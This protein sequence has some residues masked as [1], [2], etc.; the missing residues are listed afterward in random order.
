M[1]RV[2]SYL[3]LVFMFMLPV[4]VKAATVSV[5]LK[6]PSSA[7]AGTT[8]DCS[9]NVSTNTPI[10]GIVG[11][12]TLVGASYVSFTPQSGFSANYVSKDGFN[13]GNNAGRI[14][15]YSAGTLKVKVT[16]AASITIR[17][18]DISDTA[19]Q[20]YTAAN[21]TATIK[22]K[23]SNNKLSGLSLSEGRLSPAFSAS[24]LSY[25]ATV[26]SSSVTINASKGESSQTVTGTGKK[27]LNYGKNTFKVVVKSEAGTTGTYV[28]VITRPDNRSS[29][30]NLKSLSVDVGSINFKAST[31][32]Y[33][34]NVG[35]DVSSMKISADI[36]DS[37]A[38]FVKNYGARTV[39]LSYG[40]SSHQVKVKAENGSVK[41]YTIKVNREDG[42]SSNT[43]LKSLNLSSGSISFSKDVESY[44]TSVPYDVTSIVVTAEAE[45]S[46]S[47]VDVVSPSLVV[48]ENTIK[49]TVISESGA[50]R[51]YTINVTRLEEAEV[52]SNNNNVSSID[53]L[54]HGINFDPETEI[55]EINIGDE[56]ALVIEVLLED[57][58]AK[59]VIEGNENLKDGSV[60]KITSTSENGESKEYK[61]LVNKNVSAK[62]G[63]SSNSLLVGLIGFV[64]G[65]VTMFA[66]MTIIGKMKSNKEDVKVVSKPVVGSAEVKAAPVLAKPEVKVVSQPTQ[67][68]QSKVE[69]VSQQVSQPKV[70]KPVQAPVQESS[71]PVQQGQAAPATKPVSQASVQKVAQNTPVQAA[72]VQQ[73]PVML[74]ADV[75]QPV[76]QDK[77]QIPENRVQKK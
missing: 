68:P 51:V 24:V 44:T 45:D 54:G 55:Y 35:A 65:L 30:N 11:K 10:N 69:V 15:T 9:V 20:S 31:T 40:A 48:G 21:Q 72:P 49:V 26:N 46:G 14:G 67:P 73:K 47:K 37:K 32:T 29:N 71:A 62:N 57:P 18:I 38:S 50:T 12:Y 22:L 27:T 13:I 8:I 64:L 23:S 28:I 75:A 16:A 4:V 41:T 53:I 19:F 52:L 25:T 59:Y 76:A 6:C 66:T 77:N 43:Y 58:S 3:C 42:R 1:K 63:K 33:S 74:E 56:Y 39:K 70:E 61:V 34:L 36:E 7:V 2:I 5:T 17:D 60:I